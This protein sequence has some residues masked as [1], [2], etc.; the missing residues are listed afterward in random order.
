LT[1]A[2]ATLHPPARVL[3]FSVSHTERKYLEGEL[4][5]GYM[6]WLATGIEFMLDKLKNGVNQ[7]V[8]LSVT[9]G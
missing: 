1:D 9:Q 8:L 6:I 3:S 2:G 7:F 4:R 5:V